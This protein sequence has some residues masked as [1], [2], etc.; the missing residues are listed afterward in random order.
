MQ[1][2]LID[3]KGLKVPNILEDRLGRE[4]V[5]PSSDWEYLAEN[6]YKASSLYLEE[7]RSHRFTWGR[8]LNDPVNRLQFDAE[9]TIRELKEHE[10]NR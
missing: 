1:N 3:Y 7:K 6:I 2:S 10:T 8:D 5:F 9:Q 4:C